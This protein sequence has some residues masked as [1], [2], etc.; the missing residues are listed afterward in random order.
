MNRLEDAAGARSAPGD[1][2]SLEAEIA[3][4]CHA[5]YW[6]TEPEVAMT[7]WRRLRVLTAQKTAV[8]DSQ[9]EFETKGGL[10][11]QRLD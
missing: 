2:R 9:F 5:I 11:S 1:L 7:I 4:C 3:D 8:E 10:L 6:A